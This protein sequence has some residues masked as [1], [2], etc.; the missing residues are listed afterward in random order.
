MNPDEKLRQVRE[1]AEGLD[2]CDPAAVNSDQHL[3]GEVR[4]ARHVLG[5]LGPQ[6]V[7]P[8][9]AECILGTGDVRRVYVCP[10]H[11]LLDPDSLT[12]GHKCCHCEDQP[13]LRFLLDSPTQPERCSCRYGPEWKGPRLGDDSD[14]DPN[15]PIHGGDDG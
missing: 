7:L 12:I 5:L 3:L 13:A 6:D 15:C 8:T 4:A 14:R 9:V 10:D 1:W 11:G 2:G